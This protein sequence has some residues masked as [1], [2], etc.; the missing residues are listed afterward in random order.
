MLQNHHEKLAK[1]KQELEEKQ[2]KAQKDWEALKNRETRSAT[3]L[4]K[5]ALKRTKTK[6][7]TRFR[8]SEM[9]MSHLPQIRQAV[10]YDCNMFPLTKT[11]SL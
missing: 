1:Q 7:P 3:R 4:F 9:L 11:D 2:R 5:K 8:H 10:E 6:S